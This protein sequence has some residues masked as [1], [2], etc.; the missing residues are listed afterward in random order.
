MT[1]IPYGKQ[2]IEDDDI[3]A[4]VSVLK[5][6]WMTQGPTIHKFESMFKEFVN[7]D[8]AVAVSN[9]T[10][11]LHITLLALDIGK[12]DEVITTPNS[13]LATS[14]AILYVGAKPVF[15]DIEPS[16]FGID[17]N[18][19]EAAITDKTKAIIPVHFGGFPVNLQ[20]IQS[21]AEKYKLVVVE[22]ACHALGG[23][24]NNTKIGSSTYSNCSTFS[25]HPV[26]HI[27]TGEG[28]MITTNSKDIYD[29]LC[30]LRT[31]GVTKDINK[32]KQNSGPWYYEMQSLGFNYRMTDFQAALGVSQLK[33]LPKFIKKR[34]EI[35]KQY[36]QAFEPLNWL[37]SIQEHDSILSAYHL[38]AVQIDFRKIKKTRSQVMQELK[39]KGVGTQVHY[40]PI[41]NQPY[42][43]ENV[44]IDGEF[45]NTNNFYEKELSL[46]M[47]PLMKESD[48]KTVIKAVKELSQ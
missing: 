8:Y 13:F 41:I 40:I 44:S 32:M 27:A 7:A 29:R 6:D 48:I 1:V 20:A 36:D 16:Q 11:A 34:R 43:K 3:E 45:P 39:S 42:Y 12:G 17:V 2:C 33:K 22:D 21:I 23:E 10:A 38:Y 14:N 15:V 28:G 46:P 30:M 35:A 4:V 9:G 37:Q 47:F 26:K 18:K 25:F 24:Y 19:I 31:H 5:S